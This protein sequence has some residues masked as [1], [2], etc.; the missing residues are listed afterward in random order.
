MPDGKF[1]VSRHAPSYPVG[2]AAHPWDNLPELAHGFRADA[3]AAMGFDILRT[4][5]LQALLARGWRRI[6]VTSPTHGAGKSFVA[7]N[8][9][10]SLARRPDSRTVL[11][12]LE[13]RR[14]A[15]A[16]MLG[17]KAAPIEGFLSGAPCERHFRRIGQTLA[18]GLND[19]PVSRAAEL[20]QSPAAGRALGSMIAQLDPEVVIYDLPPAL[21]SDDLLAML[22]Q[23]DAVLLVAD[24]TRTTAAEIRICE[25]MLD[26]KVPLLGVVLNRAQDRDLTRYSYGKR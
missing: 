4:Q 1:M 8:L 24:G 15:L 5:L 6:A 16:G 14:P 10:F 22:P 25:R 12:D 19:R 11:V 2:V 3:E 21:G 7:A 9:A 23:I 20:L 18:V 17:A 13:L 26:N